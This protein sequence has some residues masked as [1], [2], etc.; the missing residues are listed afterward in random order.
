MQLA[1]TAG[2][3]AAI[4][5]SAPVKHYMAANSWTLWTPVA[6][7]LVLILVLAFSEQASTF[8]A[9]ICACG[10]LLS[11]SDVRLHLVVIMMQA[12]SGLANCL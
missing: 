9:P 5:Y 11:T 6:M 10:D 1:L 4:I 3:T 8:P 2:V 7:S 12:L